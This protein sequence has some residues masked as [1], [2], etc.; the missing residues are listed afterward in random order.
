[1]LADNPRTLIVRSSVQTQ[2][3]QDTRP[4]ARLMQGATA[5]AGNQAVTRNFTNLM[6]A[7]PT[8]VH[9]STAVQCNR[10]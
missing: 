7:V 10:R 9:T 8:Q 2:Q 1:M 3:L 4:P 6:P 5:V